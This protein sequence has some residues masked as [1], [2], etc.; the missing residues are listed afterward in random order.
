MLMNCTHAAARTAAPI[1]A[2]VRS[3]R[4]RVS[5]AKIWPSVF[6]PHCGGWQEPLAAEVRSPFIKPFVVVLGLLC[7]S[8]TPTGGAQ[9]RN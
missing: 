2:A 6:A 5:G 1:G 4:S 9:R 3:R 8:S 7:Q